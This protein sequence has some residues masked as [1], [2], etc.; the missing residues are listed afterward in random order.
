MALHIRVLGEA[1]R[2]NVVHLV[3]DSGQSLTKLLF[4][5]GDGC[6]NELAV[7][8]LQSIDVA[9]FSHYH[10][11]HVAGFDTLLRHNYNRSEGHLTLVGPDETFR[12]LHHRLRGFTWNLVETATGAIELRE[13][14]QGRL[15]RAVFRTCERFETAAE[16]ETQQF[17]GTVYRDR[18]L[19]IHAI[20]LDHG[21]VCAGYKVIEHDR[22]NVDTEQIRSLGLQPGP[23]IQELKSSDSGDSTRIEIDGQRYELGHLRERLIRRTAGESFAY[24]TDF[25]VPNECS[26]NELVEF[27]R[28]VDV[29]VCENNYCD[30]DFELAA[31]NFHL[32]SSEVGHLARQ[33]NVKRLILFHI[34]ARY[35]REAWGQQLAEVRRHFPAAEWPSTW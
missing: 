15:A 14:K 25:R 3:S 5:C 33:A 10:I 7:S 16:A 26:R 18:N 17:D 13:F 22:Q 29:L 2:D 8:E 1:G 35:P 23:W 6:L 32:T 20:E 12:V 21:C 31:K 9:L 24:L 11:D 30:D 27:I 34:S 19:S 28:G 4:D